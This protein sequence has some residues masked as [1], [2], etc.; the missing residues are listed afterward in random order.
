MQLTE[1]N[2]KLVY[3]NENRLIVSNARNLLEAEGIEVILVNEFAG[4]GVGDLS[5]IDSW[6][7]I[8]V[9]NDADYER[10]CHRLQTS[11]SPVGAAQWLCPYC[12]ELNDVSFETCWKCQRE[13]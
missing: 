11:L 13:R 5:A 2:V 12:R 4:G 6:P 3:T 10:A 9:A 8:W 7:E 1:A